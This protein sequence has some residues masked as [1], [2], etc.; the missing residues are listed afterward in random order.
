MGVCSI[1]IDTDADGSV[2]MKK[3][4]LHRLVL[5]ERVTLPASTNELRLTVGYAQEE[6]NLMGRLGTTV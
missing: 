5:D 1:A 3:E 2:C 4:K 6:T